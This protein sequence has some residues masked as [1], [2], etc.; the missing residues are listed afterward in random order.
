ME[1]HEAMLKDLTTKATEQS[2]VS[3]AFTLKVRL[4]PC[5]LPPVTSRRS[6]HPRLHLTLCI[7]PGA[8]RP[9]RLAPWSQV[10]CHVADL[11]NCAIRWPLSKMWAARVCEEAVAQAVRE[12]TLGLPFGRVTPYGSEDLMSRQLVFLDGWVNPLFKAAAILYPGVRG[13][14]DAI[15]ECRCV[16]ATDAG[17]GCVHARCSWRQ[18]WV[19]VDHAGTNHSACACM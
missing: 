11:G 5:P 2:M 13:R 12:Q 10:I 7:P 4:S 1:R 3:C 17:G 19:G 6:T 15:Q 18:V 16:P 9:V 8:S 14:L